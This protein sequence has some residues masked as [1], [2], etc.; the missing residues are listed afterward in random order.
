MRHVPTSMYV[1]TVL[2]KKNDQSTS[3]MY[4]SSAER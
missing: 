1:P 3:I 2:C 4:V